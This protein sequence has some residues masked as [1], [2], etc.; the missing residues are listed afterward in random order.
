MATAAPRPGRPRRFTL[1]RWDRR[2]PPGSAA[3]SAADPYDQSQPD[4]ARLLGDEHDA[5][6]V[7]IA[8]NPLQHHQ[9]EAL[10]EALE[11]RRAGWAVAASSTDALLIAEPQR[12]TRTATQ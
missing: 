3:G 2:R 1:G 7:R 5:S 4:G 11:V 10:D 12:T 6:R 9:D 8:R